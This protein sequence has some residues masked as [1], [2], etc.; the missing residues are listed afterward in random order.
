MGGRT[1]NNDEEKQSVRDRIH[2]EKTDRK[3]R[4]MKGGLTWINAVRRLTINVQLIWKVREI[5]FF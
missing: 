4:D 2:K 5:I 3:N 1:K